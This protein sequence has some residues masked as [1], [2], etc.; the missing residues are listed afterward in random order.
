LFGINLL[1]QMKAPWF[2]IN[3]FSAELTGQSIILPLGV[4]S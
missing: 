3:W 2:T 4:Y 1:I